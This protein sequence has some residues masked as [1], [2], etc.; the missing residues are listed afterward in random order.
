MPKNYLHIW[1]RGQFMMIALP[2]LDGSFT[3][4]LFLPFEMFKTIETQ[5]AGIAFMEEHFPDSVPIFGRENLMKQFGPGTPPGKIIESRKDGHG[6]FLRI[7]DD[8]GEIRTALC[9]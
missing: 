3:C 1:P 7:T 6:L 8:L 2:N 4:T 9:G 5:E